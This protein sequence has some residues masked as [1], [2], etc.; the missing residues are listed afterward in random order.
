MNGVLALI[1]A[2]II[3]GGAG[4]I[5]KFALSNIPPFTLAF[6]RFFG[7]FIIFSPILFKYNIFSIRPR[8]WLLI[9]TGAF[10]AITVNISFFFLGL[11]R[12]DSINISIIA[13]GSPLFLFLLS[14]LILHEK[15]V[16]KVFSGMLIS[17]LG[18]LVIIF[19]PLL[20]KG[21]GSAQQTAL[22]GNL[23]FVVSVLGVTIAPLFWKGVMEKIS[24]YVVTVISFFFSSLTFLPFMI[25]E[26]RTW[27]FSN[28]NGAGITGIIYG[29]FFSSAAAYFF[30]IYGISKIKAQEVGLF[31]YI[32]PVVAVLI[33]GP[34]L[35]EFPT[36]YFFV[37]S[38]LVFAGVYVSERRIPYHPFHK[39]RPSRSE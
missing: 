39:L 15:P 33:A 34:L 19:S 17:F 13:S 24:P 29:I 32:D 21:Q 11:Q 23:M 20:L 4:P 30:Y 26:L 9:L 36:T 2:N 22:I 16:S 7:A 35:Q 28:L 18:V 5:F 14:V 27:N 31:Q 6:I 38:I 37:G 10:F 8:Q 1:I 3:W 25:E 12:T